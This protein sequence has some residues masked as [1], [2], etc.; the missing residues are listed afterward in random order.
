MYYNK[1]VAS[2]VTAPLTNID[3]ERYDLH[4]NRMFVPK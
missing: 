4:D 3:N 2:S 1:G